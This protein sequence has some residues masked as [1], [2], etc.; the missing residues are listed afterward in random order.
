MSGEERQQAPTFYLL[1]AQKC[2]TSSLHYYLHQHPDVCVSWPKEPVFFEAY[3]DRGLQWYWNTY[4]SH[5]AG[6]PVIGEARV[7]NLYLPYVAPRIKEVSPSAKLV[8]IVRN[9]VDRAFSTWMMW[10]ARGHERRSFEEAVEDELARLESGPGLDGEDGERRWIDNLIVVDR[11]GLDFWPREYTACVELGHYARQ[12]RRY[13]EFFPR[14]AL[15]VLF[16]EDLREDPAREMQRLFRFLDV[17]PNVALED[18]QVLNRSFLKK[19]VQ[20]VIR[21]RASELGSGAE[22]TVTSYHRALMN[23]ETR[24]LL[25]EHYKAHNRDLGLLLDVDLSGWD[26]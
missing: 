23:P 11:K 2:G 1:G 6:E 9:P 24:R 7:R 15:H 22:A 14:D 21:D 18:L 10:T 19:G 20:R 13:L 5:W 4:F 12:L 26:E 25:V 17:D 16:T 8:A 3:W